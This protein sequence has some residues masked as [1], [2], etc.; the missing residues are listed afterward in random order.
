MP[1]LTIGPIQPT[2]GK[3]NGIFYHLVNTYNYTNPIESGFVIP[4]ASNEYNGNVNDTV[5]WNTDIFRTRLSNGNDVYLQFKFPGSFLYPSGYSIR[6]VTSAKNYYYQSEW[7]LYGF[8]E[9]EESDSN[10]WDVIVQNTSSETNFCGGNNYCDG[11]TVYTYTFKQTNKG[12]RYIRWKDTKSTTS[13]LI[14]ATSGIDVFGT[15][16]TSRYVAKSKQLKTCKKFL[17]S[18]KYSFATFFYVFILSK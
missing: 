11:K 17:I 4:S 2:E 9:G 10:K 18:S 5:L 14:F 13:D 15:L 12:Y 1:L 16:T 3:L 8:N 6:G 7:T